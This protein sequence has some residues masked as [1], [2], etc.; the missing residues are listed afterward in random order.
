MRGFCRMPSGCQHPARSQC[1]DWR[2]RRTWMLRSMPA[3]AC[4]NGTVG[5]RAS[6]VPALVHLNHDV[7]RLLTTHLHIT[8]RRPLTFA[9]L[10][11]CCP[12]FLDHPKLVLPGWPRPLSY[13]EISMGR[14]KNW[15]QRS[16]GHHWS[17]FVANL[18]QTAL[19]RYTIR[20]ISRFGVLEDRGIS[21]ATVASLHTTDE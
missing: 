4:R 5:S 6:A 20:R 15:T 8:R 3:D 18:I 10:G 2:R 17:I 9:S 1:A 13:M 14:D 19:W 11:L 12:A 21:C 16:N 7:R